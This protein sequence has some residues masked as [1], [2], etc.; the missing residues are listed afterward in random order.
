MTTV[1]AFLEMHRN[2]ELFAAK[3]AEFDAAEKRAAGVTAQ[4]QALM[5]QAEDAQRD[6]ARINDDLMRRMA[7]FDQAKADAEADLRARRDRLDTQR[8]ECDTLKAALI[9][10]RSKLVTERGNAQQ[11]ETD[12]AQREQQAKET[13]ALAQAERKSI[14][15]L[16]SALRAVMQDHGA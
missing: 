12:A 10:E 1:D 2:P 11:R 7:E 14:A 13:L 16:V 3:M 6:S 9:D 4:A 15:S 5:A 8:A